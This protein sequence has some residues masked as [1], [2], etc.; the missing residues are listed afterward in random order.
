VIIL[1]PAGV[2]MG[3]LIPGPPR[4]LLAQR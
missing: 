2:V 4:L 3:S 1:G